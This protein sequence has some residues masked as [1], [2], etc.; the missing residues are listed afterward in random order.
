LGGLVLNTHN[1]IN[2]FLITAAHETDRAK[3]V[4]D[5]LRIL[6]GMQIAEAIYPSREKIPFLD[7]IKQIS[8]TRTGYA[9][10]N[11]EIG[12]LLSSRHVWRKIAQDAQNDEELFLILESDSWINNITL[13]ENCFHV[14]AK[15]Y[16]MF[17]FGSWLGN[18][19]IFRSTRKWLG[20]GF[21]YGTPFIKTIS[22]GYG[23]AINRKAAIHL[24]EKSATI[25]YPVDE[26]KRYIEPGYLR[27]GAVVP[28]IISEKGNSSTIGERP[29]APS[30]Q[31][32]KMLL[33][34]IRNTIICFFR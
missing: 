24:L 13:L 20:G 16:D 14:V 33:L 19:K 8:F 23:Y 25:A 12:I 29:T 22:G 10:N 4:N 18:T 26:F 1:R 11:G 17:F 5:L 2:G 34:T 21:V 27:I 9:L 15:E 32:F 30:K 31:Q 7:K 28:E 3:R 6:P